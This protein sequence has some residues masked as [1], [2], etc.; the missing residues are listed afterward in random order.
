MTPNEAENDQWAEYDSA[1]EWCAKRNKGKYGDVLPYLLSA[2]CFQAIN[3]DPDAF[4]ERVRAVAYRLAME[5][6]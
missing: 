6:S 1:A 3:A 4:T 2:E 5:S